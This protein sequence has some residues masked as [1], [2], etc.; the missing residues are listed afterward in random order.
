MA[1]SLVPLAEDLVHGVDHHFSRNRIDRR[2]AQLEL[3]ARLRHNANTFAALEY[4][5]AALISSHP[6]EYPRAM[7]LVWVVACIFND[8]CS[9]NP[10]CFL[11]DSIDG[12]RQ[13]L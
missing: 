10:N 2:F 3:Q 1:D 8:I 11:R 12:N 9:N 6:R 13:I 5:L 7:G 4:D